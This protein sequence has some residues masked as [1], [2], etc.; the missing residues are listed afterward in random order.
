MGGASPAELGGG[1][2]GPSCRRPSGQTSGQAGACYLQGSAQ[3]LGAQKSAHFLF[4]QGL[5]ALLA[6]QLHQPQPR[7]GSP[8]PQQ[9]WRLVGE[10]QGGWH[11]HG[12]LLGQQPSHQQP[13]LQQPGQL[14]GRACGAAQVAGQL[15]CLPA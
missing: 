3:G 8:S 12:A 11:G 6:T 7:A 5:L 2:R 9:P 15:G 10:S 1:A 14:L 13:I 4:H